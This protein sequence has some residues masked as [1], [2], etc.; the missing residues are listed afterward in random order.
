MTVIMTCSCLHA[1][2]NYTSLR[3]PHF[4]TVCWRTWLRGG[5]EMTSFICKNDKTNDKLPHTLH[6]YEHTKPCPGWHFNCSTLNLTSYHNWQPQVDPNPVITDLLHQSV[7]ASFSPLLSHNFSISDILP[8]PPRSS[9]LFI[10][11]SATQRPFRKAENPISPWHSVASGHTG[12]FWFSLEC[13]E[14]WKTVK[15]SG[16]NVA[17]KAQKLSL[18][19]IQHIRP[20]LKTSLCLCSVSVAETDGGSVIEPEFKV[21][22][23]L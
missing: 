16:H 13:P 23:S 12:S 18:K 20:L 6:W 19:S 3:K 7:M 8:T 17:V 11:F 9:P 15:L 10:T 22:Y 14:L 21:G 2:C 4:I 5:P 1:L